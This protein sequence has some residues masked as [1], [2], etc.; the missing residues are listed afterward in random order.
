MNPD[1]LQMPLD[2]Q[3]LM[4]EFTS[5]GSR[6]VFSLI[7]QRNH[8]DLF[9]FATWLSGDAELARDI[10]Q[11][12]FLKVF[13]KPQ[14]FDPNKSLKVWLFSIAKNQW[15]N[16]IRYRSIRKAEEPAESLSSLQVEEPVF[17]AKKHLV[18]KALNHL[19]F[20]HKEVVMLKYSN[21]LTIA[22][23]SDYL[24]CSEGT[25]KSRLFYALKKLREEIAQQ[26]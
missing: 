20:D 7:Y 11:N 6:E 17:N 4:H 22:E 10:T 5:S 21:N 19:S 25:V 23:I 14:L 16:E 12:V 18:Q 9:R 13:R 26:S 3:K 8:E 1:E 15:K 24:E 2:D